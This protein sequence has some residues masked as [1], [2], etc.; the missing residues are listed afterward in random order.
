[1]KN[2][3]TRPIKV[4]CIV[5]Y[6]TEGASNR[7]R[8]EQYLPFLRERGIECTLSAFVSRRFF[9]ILY[10]EGNAPRK[11]W[12]FLK[13]VI[14]RIYDVLRV[15]AYDVVIIHREACPFGPPVFE[16]LLSFFKKPIIYDFDDA[17]YLPNYDPANRLYSFFKYPAKTRK[18]IRLSSHVIVANHFLKRFAEQ[19]SPRVTVIPTCVD[20]ERYARRGGEAKGKKPVIGWVGSKTTAPYLTLL[21]P[22]LQRLARECDFI[23]RVVGASAPIVIPG[24][25]VEN[26]PWSLESEWAYFSSLD[27]GVYPL[28][29]DEWARGKA[30]FKAILYMCAGIPVVASGVGMNAEVVKDGENGFLAS[31]AD[32][33]YEKLLRLVQDESLRRRFAE[34]GRDTVERRFSLA[35]NAP[36]FADIIRNV[37]MPEKTNGRVR[38]LHL[39]TDLDIGGTPIVLNALLEHPAFSCYDI[40]VGSLKSRSVMSVADQIESRGTR[41]IFFDAYHFN[42]P[43]IFW[44]LYLFLRDY[45]ID[46]IHSWLFHA[47]I[48]GRICGCLA[49][50]KAVISTELAIDLQKGPVRVFL[51]KVTSALSTAIITNARAVKKALVQR[52]GIDPEKITVIHNGIDFRQFHDTGAR[53]IVRSYLGFKKD[54]IVLI[55]V[56][57][58]HPVKGHVYLIDAV[59]R[60]RPHIPRLTLLFVGDG[61]YRRHIER[62]VRRERLS[63]AVIFAGVAHDVTSFLDAADIFVLP[64][65]EEG[66]PGSI[67]EAMAMEKPV[68]ASRIG[69]IPEM[70]EDGREGLLVA[71]RDITGLED[72][73]RKII[74]DE[75]FA[76]EITGHARRKVERFTIE[77]MARNIEKLYEQ[78]TRKP[79]EAQHDEPV[80]YHR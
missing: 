20:T 35:V 80:A 48:L 3:N 56:A 68:I 44:R 14:R 29:N 67:L 53:E 55:T 1:M 45:R 25:T 69:G 64:S 16:R 49:G 34:R 26:I 51:D 10:K 36:L 15:H 43:L 72:A 78:N 77:S 30:A 57:R 18:I 58:L 23:F 52:E 39:I 31:S 2:D 50:V 12:Y 70:I 4:L 66:F 9:S 21:Y 60:L 76:H 7:Y 5:P 42:T 32:E 63:G 38:V 79:R 73:V 17:I 41:V 24:V 61:L 6:S 62:K 37:R 47:N 65:L 28:I 33:W 22:V 11:L 71:P 13:G 8:I 27:I 74:E 46:I 40:Y 75:H 54:D 19:H 59:K